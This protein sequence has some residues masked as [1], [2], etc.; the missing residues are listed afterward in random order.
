MLRARLTRADRWAVAIL[1]ALPVLL[2]VPWALAG[3]PVLDGDN[4]TQNYPLRVLVGQ[5]L[6]HGRLP[7]WDPGIWSGVELLGGWNAGAMF[8]GTWLFAFI[9]GIA[10]FEVNIVAAGIVCGLGLHL[11]LRRQ[12]CSPLGSLLG[13][14]CFSEMGFMSGQQAHL[15]LVEG[16]ALVPVMLLATDG[17]WRCA[18][19]S[20]GADPIGAFVAAAGHWI[21]ILG[22]AVGLSVLAGDP[23]AVSS[24]VI[25]AAIFLLACCWRSR[26]AA[27]RLLLAA[28]I[29]AV[30]GAAVGAAQ[31]LPGLSYLHGSQRAGGGIGL[32]GFGSLG[33]GS[34]PLLV[35][36]YLAGGNGNL[37]MPD[38]I[39]P[40]NTP[41]VT[42]A[43][44]ILPVVAL[45]ALAPRLRRG[46]E[47]LGVWYAMAVVGAVLAA[48]TKTPLGHL[49][50]HLPLYGGQRLQNRN[51]A[52]V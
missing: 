52:I 48:G 35:T 38:Y 49:L 6:R 25:T 44:G 19:Q 21:G 1:V 34:L 9:P 2:N 29:S 24:D 14:L 40:L 50:V 27:R 45:F 30:L 47:P 32:F 15:G 37:G 5:I 39:G 17:L 28:A 26:L 51:T 23:R 11:F 43:V 8:P 4:L 16:T 22:L 31:W 33:L 3:R 41:E 18:R 7:L 10:A 20:A 12:G 46:G 36:P 42:F 13:A